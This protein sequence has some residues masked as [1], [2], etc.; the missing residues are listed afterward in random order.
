MKTELATFG[1]GCF[2]GVQQMYD[3]IPGV[4]ETQVGYMGGQTE[5][6]SY[7]EVCTDRTGHAEVVHI[8]YNPTVVS[9]DK[10][11]DLFWKNH[12]PTEL[13]KQGP[14]EGTQYRSTIFYHSDT[15]KATAEKSLEELEESAKY[16]E[17]I[18][19]QIMPATTFYAAE[20]YHQ[21][22][23]DKRGIVGT[24]HI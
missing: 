19:T 13:N 9:Y 21:K 17:P 24:C 2:W 18:V 11:L 14:D 8:E 16:E 5:E 4:V 23:F 7:D 10:L 3:Q 20:D 1:A 12:N 15:Q 22:Y 6:P